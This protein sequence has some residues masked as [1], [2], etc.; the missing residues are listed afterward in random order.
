MLAFGGLLQPFSDEPWFLVAV[1][2]INTARHGFAPAAVEGSRAESRSSSQSVA[3]GL[4]EVVPP[5]PVEVVA[6]VDVLP[7]PRTRSASARRSPLAAP[8]AL[9]S[10]AADDPMVVDD[11]AVRSF[12]LKLN[13]D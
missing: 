9:G 10:G 8:I 5:A 1:D 11:A 12:F 7:P 13:I 4:S 6:E 3:A 2:A